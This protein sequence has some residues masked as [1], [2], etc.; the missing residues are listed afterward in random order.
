LIFQI[1]KSLV[2]EEKYFGTQIMFCLIENLCSKCVSHESRKLYES[3]VFEYLRYSTTGHERTCCKPF[4]T[5][6]YL[7]HVEPY[8]TLILDIIFIVFP[9]NVV[10][11]HHYTFIDKKKIIEISITAKC[12]NFAQI[13]VINVSLFCIC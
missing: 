8:V 13:N 11:N 5:L 9:L 12:T 6:G 10:Y 7:V 1:K 3:A 2:E 4:S